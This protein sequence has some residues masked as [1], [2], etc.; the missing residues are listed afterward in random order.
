MI[1]L[2]AKRGEL[3]SKGLRQLGTRFAYLILRRF[4]S[5]LGDSEPDLPKT[6]IASFPGRTVH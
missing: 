2:G 3:T 5:M 6:V 4:L 1:N